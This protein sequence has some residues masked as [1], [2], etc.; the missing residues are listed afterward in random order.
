MLS[1]VSV[2]LANEDGLWSWL[3]PL[4][5]AYEAKGLLVSMSD[6][7]LQYLGTGWR[8]GCVRE[9]ELNLSP[10][11]AEF[12]AIKLTAKVIARGMK[13]RTTYI[14]STEVAQQGWPALEFMS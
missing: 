13:S 7:I 4:K 5:Q 12:W 10:S 14:A 6:E 2:S 3:C 1:L 8:S 9:R 11:V